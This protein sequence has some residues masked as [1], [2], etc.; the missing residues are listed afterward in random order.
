M[1]GAERKKKLIHDVTDDTLSTPSAS[2]ADAPSSS[3]QAAQPTSKQEPQ[4]IHRSAAPSD[5]APEPSQHVQ[6]SKD[7]APTTTTKP[8]VM[9]TCAVPLAPCP[10]PLPQPSPGVAQQHQ[11]Q[12]FGNRPHHHQPQ[13]IP[14]VFPMSNINGLQY[15]S[16]VQ[17]LLPWATTHR[18]PP[19]LTAGPL[20]RRA[21]MFAAT[22]TPSPPS[23]RVSS[24]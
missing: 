23:P 22:T 3:A 11:V 5:P 6:A 24:P 17:P 18:T 8:A 14:I 13:T 21:Q 12:S 9:R 1:S 7:K 16:M 15:A 20:L 4:S 2:N 19:T 10:P